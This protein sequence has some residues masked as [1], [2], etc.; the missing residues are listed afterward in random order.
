MDQNNLEL[1][2]NL[3]K[4][5]QFVLH[6]VI[7]T[8]DMCRRPFTTSNP[9]NKTKTDFL[10]DLCETKK[11]PMIENIGLNELFETAECVSNTNSTS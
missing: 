9:K 2:L 8:A 6:D 7:T 5:Q 4:T 11:K 10:K 3:K 1:L